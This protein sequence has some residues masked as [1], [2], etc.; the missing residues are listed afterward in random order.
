MYRKLNMAATIL[1]EFLLADN[2]G[3]DM[4]FQEFQSYFT[5]KLRH[6]D[7]LRQFYKAFRR[8]H[9][10][11]HS[12]TK[13]NIYQQYGEDETPVNGEDTRLKEIEATLINLDTVKLDLQ[14]ELSQVN[15]DIHETDEQIEKFCETIRQ[16]NPPNILV[17]ADRQDTLQA[18]EEML[19]KD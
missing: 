16:S 7:S 14:L 19:D 12:I 5:E 15:K 4:T 13:K 11:L 8:H 18:L 17:T 2:M 6:D 10:K 9:K 3:K 1:E